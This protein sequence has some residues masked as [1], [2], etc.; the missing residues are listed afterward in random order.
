MLTI[1]QVLFGVLP[2]FIA[3][4]ALLAYILRDVMLDRAKYIRDLT[5]AYRQLA[6]SQDNLDVARETNRRLNRRVQAS[7]SHDISQLRPLR[8]QLSILEHV[9]E[10]CRE[11][12][13]DYFT[14]MIAYQSL[15]RAIG[16][17][18]TEGASR[19]ESFDDL[20]ARTRKDY[21]DHQAFLTTRCTPLE[22]IP[23]L[24]PGDKEAADGRQS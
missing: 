4:S 17:A 1:E 10:R 8:V 20:V 21:E 12:R 19:G 23:S 3:L 5:E 6:A 22:K 16:H 18:S 11:D 15:V 7:E 9:H 2:P 14:K 13:D 24:T